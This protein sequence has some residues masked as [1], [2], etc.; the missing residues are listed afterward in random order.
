MNIQSEIGKVISGFQTSFESGSTVERE[1]ISPLQLKEKLQAMNLPGF[2]LACAAHT[3]SE[4]LLAVAMMIRAIST[5]MPSAGVAMCMHQHVV[6]TCARHQGIFPMISKVLDAVS[7]NNALVSSAFA[8]G[9]PSSDIFR[10]SV[11]I[12]YDNE[13]IILN[14]SKKP[15]TLS[16]IADFHIMSGAVNDGEDNNLRLV[17]LPS[18]S[19]GISVKPFYKINLLSASDSNLVQLDN[20]TLDKVWGGIPS[21]EALEPALSYGMGMFNLFISAAYSGVL[22]AFIARLPERL[23]AD[24]AVM[25][26]ITNFQLTSATLIG[27]MAEISHGADQSEMAVGQVLALRYQVEELLDRVGRFLMMRAGG[28]AI[29]TNPDLLY[30]QNITQLM[31]YHPVTRHQFL[32][33]ASSQ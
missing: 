6:L 31:K 28:I 8:E 15:C 5:E 18:G 14:G 19:E 2:G 4:A 11:S 25:N 3:D 16:S 22:D 29:M 27:T 13:K 21:G 9:I 17:I 1:A 26:E 30:L 12:K 32:T 33:E 20:V 10:P 24:Q 7:T 23:F